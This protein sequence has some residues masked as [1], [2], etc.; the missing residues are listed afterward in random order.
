MSV[1]YI[2]AGLFFTPTMYKCE[3]LP[4]LGGT[5][6]VTSNVAEFI[7]EP[8]GIFTSNKMAEPIFCISIFAFPAYNAGTFTDVHSVPLLNTAKPSVPVFG[9]STISPP[10]LCIG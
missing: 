6:G 2:G 9:I 4:E 3:S 5:I 10:T 8:A 7:V 1:G